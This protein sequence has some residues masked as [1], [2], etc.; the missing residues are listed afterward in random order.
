MTSQVTADAAGED[1][2]KQAN[3]KMA[4]ISPLSVGRGPRFGSVTSFT[5][6]NGGIAQPARS[7]VTWPCP[8][9]LPSSST[10]YL[11]TEITLPEIGTSVP[12]RTRRSNSSLIHPLATK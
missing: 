5:G 6:Q 3:F 10:L 12:G 7:R 9:I 11:P 8:W 2:A 1:D 4:T